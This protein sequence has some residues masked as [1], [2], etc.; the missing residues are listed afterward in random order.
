MV[1][2]QKLWHRLFLIV[3]NSTSQHA[4]LANYQQYLRLY[5]VVGKLECLALKNISIL[6]YYL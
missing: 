2:D 1:F 6:V 3:I 5:R 4:L